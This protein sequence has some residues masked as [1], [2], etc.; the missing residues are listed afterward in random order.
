[1]DDI[2]IRMRDPR[3]ITEAPLGIAVPTRS[4]SSVARSLLICWWEAAG[5]DMSE[6]EGPLAS[7]LALPHVQMEKLGPGVTQHVT[8]QN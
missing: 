3:N 6:Q 5:M 2:L 7:A 8:G 1:M 4:P